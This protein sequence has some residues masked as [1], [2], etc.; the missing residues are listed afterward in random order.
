VSHSNRTSE[1][2]MVGRLSDYV[3]SA[4]EA[5]LVL[6]DMEVIGVRLRFRQRRRIWC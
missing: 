4:A 6:T 1:P 3:E 2:N 5:D